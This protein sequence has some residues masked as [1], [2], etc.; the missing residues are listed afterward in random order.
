MADTKQVVVDGLTVETTAQG[1]QAIEKLQGQ[2]RD[3]AATHAAAIAAKDAAL[4]KA[5]G[6]R[7]AALAKVLT[8]A[9]IDERVSA[10]ADLIA[11]AKS[12]HDADFT[13]KTDADIRRTVVQAKVG[14][15][16]VTGKS[17]D[18]VA[19]RFDALL[20]TDPMREHMRG[21]PT[22][23]NDGKGDVY[24]KRDADMANAWR[25]KAAA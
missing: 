1:A 17:D 9:Q 14:D 10:R 13:G 23:T 12:V 4:G 6:E 25:N 16:A 21:Q 24:A 3:S 2:L 5:E 8:D 18:Y 7:D 15:A 11:K 22:A 20:N 19:A